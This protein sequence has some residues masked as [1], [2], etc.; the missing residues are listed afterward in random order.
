LNSAPS[1]VERNPNKN[2]EDIQI[3]SESDHESCDTVL[4][5]PHDSP[6]STKNI[7]LSDE[8]KADPLHNIDLDLFRLR[9]VHQSKGSIIS[10]KF[11]E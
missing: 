4:H 6:S 7:D 5:Q 8:D 3:K 10:C 11:E 1:I 9:A 2:E